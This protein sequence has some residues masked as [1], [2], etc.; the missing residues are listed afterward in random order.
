MRKAD[1]LPTVLVLF[2]AAYL[3]LAGF[4]FLDP[5]IHI[6]KGPVCFFHVL[7]V[8]HGFEFLNFG[9][10][11]SSFHAD[12]GLWRLLRFAC[13]DRPRQNAESIAASSFFASSLSLQQVLRFSALSESLSPQ[14]AFPN[15]LCRNG[16]QAI[17]NP[18]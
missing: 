8:G 12:V 11:L 17:A 14:Q 13:D 2:G 4:Q 1:S 10:H 15:K 18:I 9:F 16:P 3:R 5:R 7:S 6:R